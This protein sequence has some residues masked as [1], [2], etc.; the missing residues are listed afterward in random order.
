MR[1]ACHSTFDDLHRGRGRA[2]DHPTSLRVHIEVHPDCGSAP[3]A[4][5]LTS[6]LIPNSS[7]GRELLQRERGGP[8]D[9]IIE[10]RFVAASERR[11][12]R[13]DS[14]HE[15]ARSLRPVPTPKIGR[16]AMGSRWHSCRIF[17]LPASDSSILTRD[18]LLARLQDFRGGPF[19]GLLDREGDKTCRAAGRRPRRT[20]AS[21]Q[22]IP[23]FR[24]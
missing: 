6:L 8:H 19:I 1:T 11:I 15:R 12:A 10:T 9:P 21:I 16:T 4:A 5:C 18:R 3:I 17:A 13:F 14:T 22:R 7:A 2:S 20:T 23:T 24:A